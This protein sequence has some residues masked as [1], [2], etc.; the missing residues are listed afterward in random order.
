M[1]R[2][3]PASLAGRT[4]LVMLGGLTML[5][6]GSVVIHEHALHGVE[7]A[8][9]DARHAERIQ[10]AR[11]LAVERDGPERDAA[12]HGLSLPGLQLHWVQQAPPAAEAPQATLAEL[13]ARLGEGA[14]AG[15]AGDVALGAVPASGGGWIVFSLTPH[16]HPRLAVDNGGLFSMLAMAIGIG[17]VAVPVVRWMTRPLRRLAEAADRVGRD[18]R[19]VML[20]TDGPVEVQHAAI[21]FNAMQGRIARLIE[22]RTEALASLSH[23]LRTPLARLKLRASFL[24]EGEERTRMEADITEMEAMVSRTLEYFREGRDAEPTVPTNLAAILQTLADDA[25]DAGHD[26]TYH[27]PAQAVLPL[28]RLAAKRAFSNLL[29]NAF[30]HGAP[31]VTITLT[32][33]ADGWVTDIADAGTGI[34]PT[35][36]ERAVSPFVRLD[37]AR[38]GSGV[39]LGLTIAQRFA[40]GEGGSLTLAQAP[41]GGLLVRVKLRG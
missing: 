5:H 39:G 11:A 1:R 19:P 3:W 17:L 29:N 6:V 15:Q 34:P 2:L 20:A 32:A 24:D 22:D 36:F 10:A 16:E 28:R 38:G 40:A 41:A 21:A 35:E 23:D 33:T 37:A 4:L 27:G 18:P 9:V 12:V 25:A 13:V 30:Q 26:V 31:P 14:R 8:A 7:M